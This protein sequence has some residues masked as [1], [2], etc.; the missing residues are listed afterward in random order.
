MINQ[1]GLKKDD[2]GILRCYG[3][4]ANADTNIE[5]KNP[6]LLPRKNCFLNLVILEVHGRLIHAGVSHTLN[7]QEFWLPKGQ[8]EVR[9]VLL[10]C[11]ICKRHNGP[12]FR[13]PIIPHWPRERVSRSEPF[14]YIGL[15]YLGP[16]GVKEGD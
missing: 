3:R 8:A 16:I 5:Q 7:Y 1:L 11:V 10:Q 4:Y 9:R 6:K 14:Q 15:D 12:S 2:H 13:L